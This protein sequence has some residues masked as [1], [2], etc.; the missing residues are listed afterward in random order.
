M[1]IESD[2]PVTPDMQAIL[3]RLCPAVHNLMVI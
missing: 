2:N 3:K 1:C